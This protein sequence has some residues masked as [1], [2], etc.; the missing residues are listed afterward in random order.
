MFDIGVVE[1]LVFVVF[2]AFVAALVWLLTRHR[3]H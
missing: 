3:G 1:L 2:V